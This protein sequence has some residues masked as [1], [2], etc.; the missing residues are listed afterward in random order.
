VIS[1]IETLAVQGQK[2]VD[3]ISGEPVSVNK[4]LSKIADRPLTGPVSSAVLKLFR[5]PPYTGKSTRPSRPSG[6]F[7]ILRVESRQARSVKYHVTDNGCC[8]AVCPDHFLA[9]RECFRL[10]NEAETEA[11]TRGE[12][13]R[14][15]KKDDTEGD[16]VECEA[17]LVEA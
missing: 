11:L 12:R 9:K 6:R 2:Y 3:K 16:E 13:Y 1:F 5:I 4:Q 15:K 7:D 17:E 14:R 8:V 10:E